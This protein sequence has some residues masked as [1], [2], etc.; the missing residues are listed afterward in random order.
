MARRYLMRLG[1]SP[2]EPVDAFHTLDRNTIGRN[3]GNLMFGT[4]AHKLFSTADTTVDANHY[5]INKGMAD[6]VNDEYDGFILPLAN[7]FRPGFEAELLRTTEFVERLN[8]PVLMLSGGAQL[9]LDGNPAALK[10][11]EPT[12]K[13]FA[14]AILEKS[15]ALSV[16]GAITAEYLAS[17][18]FHDVVVIG[19]PS[20]TMWGPGHHVDKP[21]TLNPGDPV[22]YNV[23]TNN[24]FGAALFDDAE[25]NYAATYVPQDLATLEMMLW[26]TDPYELD[27]PRVP[28][29]R[30]HR[31]YTEARAEF[32]LDAYTWLARMKEMSFAFGPRIHGSIA[33][34]LAGTPGIVLA[35]DGRTLELASYHEI[36][37]V[38]VTHN[39][40][41]VSVSELFAQT[42]FTAFNRG[43]AARFDTISDYIHANGFT[44]IY[45][46]GQEDARA[47]YESKMA[48][49]GFPPMQRALWQSQSEETQTLLAV[50]QE[51]YTRLKAQ[52][53]KTSGPSP[54][55]LQQRIGELET[56]VQ[57]AE[58]RAAAL[59]S[60]QHR[61]ASSFL[62]STKN[63]A[64]QTAR[65][66]KRAL[67]RRNS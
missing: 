34:I 66:L 2:F 33:A 48:T 28:L 51:R 44:H 11:M 13:R 38:D 23:Q 3:S 25:T 19:C 31:Q 6:R 18:G 53:K 50:L 36:P 42:D 63:N 60:E 40:T 32:P 30:S 43:H 41:P 29:H 14:R 22:A 59:E 45:D 1:K 65:A 49:I 27:D 16:R 20:M 8:I 55:A 57:A 39:E 26:A 56:R 54:A 37:H 67:S 21:D 5:S 61:R 62:A 10:K 64:R 35:H 52:K 12:V 9:P 17:L 4:A 47:A 24:P 46:K 15:S 7:A 58:Q